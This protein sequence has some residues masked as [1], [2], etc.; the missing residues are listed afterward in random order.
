M[1]DGVLT[2]AA[3]EECLAEKRRARA[4]GLD[5]SLQELLEARGLVTRASWEALEKRTAVAQTKSDEQPALGEDT[6]SSKPDGSSLVRPLADESF[7]D[8]SHRGHGSTLP[9]PQVPRDEAGRLLPSAETLGEYPDR[10]GARARRHGSRLR[11]DPGP[12]SD[13][14]SRSRSCRRARRSRESRASDSSA[15]LA[16]RRASLTHP[17]IVPI[18]DQGEERGVPYFAMELSRAAR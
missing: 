7:G 5:V 17:G 2:G 3:L 18:Y 12:A 14:A 9:D 11:G 1:K 4:D 15:R 8:G 6:P 10:P 16:P 13:A